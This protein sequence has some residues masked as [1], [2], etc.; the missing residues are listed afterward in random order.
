VT[1]SYKL[2]A[3][4]DED[5]SPVEL[6]QDSIREIGR[7]AR[8]PRRARTEI[9]C[10]DGIANSRLLSY[11]EIK[12]VEERLI[13]EGFELKPKHSKGGRDMRGTRENM[14]ERMGKLYEVIKELVNERRFFKTSMLRDSAILRARVTDSRGYF[15]RTIHEDLRRL[16]QQG[17][18]Y[19]R[20]RGS[21]SAYYLG[22]GKEDGD[23]IEKGSFKKE[24]PEA[25]IRSYDCLGIV[26]SELD[27]CGGCEAN[28]HC[29]D[30]QKR[31]EEAGVKGEE[32]A[33]LYEE[34]LIPRHVTVDINVS[35]KLG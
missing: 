6:F 32:K 13:K 8:I 28:Q 14:E 34:P 19:S 7:Y 5:V 27:E 17:L 10:R 18:I 12:K 25:K 2:K 35:F 3:L 1:V 30:V 4:F 23:R 21:T 9:P 26:H 11:E 29:H 24:E 31:L 33:S 22:D 16:A 15:N 20:G